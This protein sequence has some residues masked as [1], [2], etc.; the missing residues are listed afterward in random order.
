MLV[1]K[2]KPNPETCGNQCEDQEKHTSELCGMCKL[3]AQSKTQIEPQETVFSALLKKAKGAKGTLMLIKISTGEGY[4][5][6]SYDPETH[7]VKLKT[8][9]GKIIQPVISNREAVQYKPHWR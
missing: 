3:V 1:I 9:Q 5:V 8:G 6:Q 7:R 2:R 4:V